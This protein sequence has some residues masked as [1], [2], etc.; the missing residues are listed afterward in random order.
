MNC[1][2]MAAIERQFSA[3]IARRDLERY[4]K[5]GPDPTTR[6]I[7]DALTAIGVEDAT[8][9]DIGGGIGVL[10]HELLDLG[11]RR[12]VE[13]EP[14]PAYLEVARAEA[15]RR[16]HDERVD[17]A[18]GDLASVASD[19]VQAD[20]VTMDA[21]ICCDPDVEPLIATAAQKSGRL[22]AASF[23]QDRW[24][25]RLVHRL[26]NVIRRVRGNS[27]RTFVHSRAL[28]EQSFAAAGFRR[29]SDSDTLVWAVA[30]YERVTV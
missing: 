6:R 1:C 2:H 21:V 17:F 9:L 10:H 25:V 5:K 13:V 24:Y 19:L 8:L 14:A 22:V 30:V 15:T 3:E 27:F 7:I 26:Q 23:P 28:I 18:C 29:R 16:N 11:V 12:A 4:R 20:I